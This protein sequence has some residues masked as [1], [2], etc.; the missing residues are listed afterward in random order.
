MS[1]W[2]RLERQTHE[3]GGHEVFALVLA[4][5][6]LDRHGRHRPGPAWPVY[7]P[8]LAGVEEREPGFD[9]VMKIVDTPLRATMCP[10]CPFKPGSPY[11]NLADGLA[12][13]ACGEATRVCHSTGGNNGINRRT[14][15]PPHLCRGARDIQL[16]MFAGFGII[17]DASDESW[18][19]QRAVI[20][21][22]PT[23]IKDP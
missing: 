22:K 1:H 17:K 7:P 12:A 21:L 15:K 20:G 2:N 18:N 4:P 3:R 23:V 8:P 11:E 19:S 10:T 5:L 16:A 6:R 9:L 14:G 13:S